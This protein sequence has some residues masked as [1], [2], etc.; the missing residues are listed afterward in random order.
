[1]DVAHLLRVF[2]DLKGSWSRFTPHSAAITTLNVTKTGLEAK[3]NPSRTIHEKSM[4]MDHESN[5]SAA[6]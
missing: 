2:T 6:S 5:I 1:M 3:S 4:C